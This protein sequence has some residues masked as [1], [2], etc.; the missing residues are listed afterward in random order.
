VSKRFNDVAGGLLTATFQRLLHQMQQEYHIIRAQ[1]PRRESARR[2]HP[3]ARKWDI[4]E[5]LSMRLSLLQMTLGKHLDLN[6]IPFFPG[7]I[8]DEVFRILHYIQVTPNIENLRAFKLT[9][10]LFDLSEMAMEYF[11]EKIEP[12]LPEISYFNSE[13]WDFTFSG[14]P[15]KLGGSSLLESPEEDGRNPSELG[16]LEETGEISQP[17]SNM[18]LRKR[19]RRIRQG[20]KRYNSE[21]AVLKQELKS[22][23]KT[24]TDQNKQIRE[25]S[26]RLDSYDKKFEDSSK[27]FSLLLAELNKCKTELQYWRSKSPA[28]S[29][30][31]CR[32]CGT[33]VS[34]KEDRIQ[35]LEDRRAL[36]HQGVIIDFEEDESPA[37]E[38]HDKVA[39]CLPGTSGPSKHHHTKDQQPHS[40]RKAEAKS[41]GKGRK[42]AQRE[43]LIYPES[44]VSHRIDLEDRYI[45]QAD[46]DLRLAN[47]VVWLASIGSCL[48]EAPPIASGPTIP[49]EMKLAVACLIL[50]GALSLG[51]LAR[52]AYVLPAGMDLLGLANPRATFSCAGRIYGY[53]ADV[54]NDC[55][56]FHVCHP[57]LDERNQLLET[58]HYTFACPNQT[59]FS[60]DSLTCAFV[61]DALPCDQ[62]PSFYDSVNALFGIL[63]Q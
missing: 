44:A 42:R 41:K 4:Y 12:A 35:D 27:K 40:K 37:Y 17:Q 20:M 14:C 33:I 18:V 13:F 47:G 52:Q 58:A 38:Y 8:L 10:E 11:K 1:M 50:S 29:Q 34:G 63:G 55:K 21:L 36:A 23:Q 57:I 25:Y 28:I 45:L 59:A 56:L 32:E 22:C 7:E 2:S 5:T 43:F 54:D 6:H 31:K 46:L 61:D 9:D 48:Y 24:I 30:I 16:S 60:Q 51:V 39:D 62:A 49:H 15:G 19:I 26:T 53:Y 3:L